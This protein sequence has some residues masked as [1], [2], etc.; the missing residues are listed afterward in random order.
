[1][2]QLIS[3]LAIGLAFTVPAAAQTYAVT[4]G[5]VVTNTDAGILENATVVIR[6]GDIVAVAAGAEVPEDAT[7]IDAAGGWVTPGLFAAYSELGL[8]EVQL[9][10]STTDT[11]ADNSPFSVTLDVADG[12]NPAGTYIPTSRMEGLT[13]AAI[14]PSPGHNIFAGQ[15]ALIDTT[16][17]ADSLFQSGSFVYADLSQSGA[18]M[19]GGSRPAAWAY[20][21]AALT[22]A[23]GYPGSFSGD[24]EGDA[25]NRYDAAALLPVDSEHSAVFQALV[26]EEIAAVER[27]VITASG[28]AFRD[29][30]LERLRTATVAEASSHPNW[31]MGQRITIDSASMFNKALEV[32]EAREFFGL[33]PD[34]IEVL[35][36]PES[37]V[38]ALVG[39][40]DGGIM[41]HL[42]APDMRHAI[43][44]ALHWPDRAPLPVE[45]LDLARLGQLTFRAPDPAR[46]PALALAHRVMERGGLAGA[47]FNAA[48]ERALD[49]FIAR[50]IGF[51]D[52]AEVVARTL[53]RL[54]AQMGP[55][56]ARFDLDNILQMDHLARCEADK[57]MAARQQ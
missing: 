38:H 45:R 52:M 49:A 29:W 37:M 1:M 3:A 10:D 30:P 13:R 55:I 34:Q 57:V 33:D 36:H 24:H 7:V 19:A 2:K 17:E 25:L 27:I 22:Y 21:E 5:R 35:I 8:I 56:D 41:A 54:D 9:E 11:G 23:R 15:G 12:F 40:V 47:A 46:Y 51:T 44:Y 53:D 31:D 14:F 18:S 32:I 20:L 42:G 50:R 39:H 4:N 48:K 43:G 6:D 28:G 26:G 16:G